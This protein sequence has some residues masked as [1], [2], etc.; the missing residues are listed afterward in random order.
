MIIELQFLS[1]DIK[2]KNQTQG[3]KKQKVCVHQNRTHLLFFAGFHSFCVIKYFHIS[4]TI[5]I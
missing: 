5:N 4:I 2:R 1:T 3:S